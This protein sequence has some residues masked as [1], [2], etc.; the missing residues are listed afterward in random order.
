MK[1][2]FLIFALLLTALQAA[3]SKKAG[4]SKKVSTSKKAAASKKATTSV[5]DVNGLYTQ[6]S[7][8]PNLPKIYVTKLK[9]RSENL[10]AINTAYLAMIKSLKELIGKGD[11]TLKNTVPGIKASVA[12]WIKE[13]GKGKSRGNALI[14][15]TKA[16]NANWAKAKTQVTQLVIKKLRQLRSEARAL[17][18]KVKR[19][20]WREVNAKLNAQIDC[21]IKVLN[22]YITKMQQIFDKAPALIQQLK[23]LGV[24]LSKL[25]IDLELNQKLIAQYIKLAKTVLTAYTQNFAKVMLLAEKNPFIIAAKK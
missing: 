6:I 2:K 19:V 12:D 18:K 7:K 9:T 5:I 16:D 13:L 21:L 17:Q 10:L 15:A 22:E 23:E 14:A 3:A 20:A 25:I 24:K 8:M 1:L 11:T 4:A